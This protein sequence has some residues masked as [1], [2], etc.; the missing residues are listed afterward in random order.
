MRTRPGWS[1]SLPS[2]RMVFQLAEAAGEG[3]MLG[4][5]D[6]LVAQEQ[7]LVLQQRA[8]DLGEQAVVARGIGQ[9]DADQLG[10]DAG[11]SVVST[12]MW[13]SP[14]MTKIDEP[15]VLRASRSRCACTASASA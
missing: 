9:A 10:A 1:G 8:L 6:V 2:D 15:V 7:H 4:A 13:R 3:D 5:R 14:Q 11:R 12:R